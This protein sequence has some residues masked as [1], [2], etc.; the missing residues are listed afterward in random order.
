[1]TMSS[2]LLFSGPGCSSFAPLSHTR[3]SHSAGRQR[4]AALENASISS[5]QKNA[6]PVDSF[7]LGVKERETSNID[8]VSQKGP[9]NTW[10]DC[11]LFCK[12]SNSGGNER[13]NPLV[14]PELLCLEEF[15]SRR[16]GSHRLS[17]LSS[18]SLQ[19]STSRAARLTVPS[20]PGCRPWVPCFPGLSHTYIPWFPGLY[21]WTVTALLNG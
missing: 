14:S 13:Q 1:M 20:F 10:V 19:V 15:L 4:P 18:L 2:S 8:S 17:D 5:G 6:K 3:C 16:L 11:L 12:E 9:L 7:Q 21:Q